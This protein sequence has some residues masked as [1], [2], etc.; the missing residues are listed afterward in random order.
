VTPEAVIRAGDEH[1]LPAVLALMDG[2]VAWLVAQGRPDQWGTDPGRPAA[3]TGLVL[4]SELYLAVSGDAVVGAL[5]VGVAPAYAPPP[6]E[7]ELYVRLLVTDR[8]RTGR[9]IGGRLLDHAAGLARAK[10]VQVLRVDCYAGPD[11]ALVRYYES[12]GF[13]ATEAFEVA[14]PSGPWPGQVLERRLR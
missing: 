11:R 8:A 7:P 2:A 1:D 6:V 14:R 13:T 12:Q 4:D 3:T 5:A 9:G 10:G